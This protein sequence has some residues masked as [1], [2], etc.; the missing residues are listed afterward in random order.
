M[1]LH[2][3]VRR[4]QPPVRYRAPLHPETRFVVY[5]PVDDCVRNPH[6]DYATEPEWDAKAIE[7]GFFESH[8]DETQRYKTPF[9]RWNEIPAMHD[10]A[11]IDGLIWQPGREPWLAEYKLAATASHNHVACFRVHLSANQMGVLRAATR[12]EDIGVSSRLL[13][14]RG[15]PRRA[16]PPRFRGSGLAIGNND[17]TGTIKMFFCSFRH[18]E[19]P[20]REAQDARRLA[21]NQT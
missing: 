1:Q 5:I 6:F 20:F 15:Y 16:P 12:I 10:D 13:R 14:E 7:D 17:R 8:P 18:I 2:H 11:Q 21:P 4:R 3:S 9:P 19:Q